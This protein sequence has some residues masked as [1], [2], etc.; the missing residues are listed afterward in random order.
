[1][2]RAGGFLKMETGAGNRA[3]NTMRIR[4]LTD[5]PI[6]LALGTERL[7]LEPTQNPAIIRWTQNRIGSRH[8]EFGAS[9]QCLQVP[10]HEDIAH[11]EGIPDP[12]P[13]TI[14]LVAPHVLDN[15]DR[16][17]VF[18]FN[19]EKDDGNGNVIIDCLVGK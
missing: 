7:C 9:H 1:M 17:D 2:D 18:T 14:F 19:D 8:I 4:N 3:R 11:V 10:I 13:F 6:I 5:T 16:Q 12:E 15:C